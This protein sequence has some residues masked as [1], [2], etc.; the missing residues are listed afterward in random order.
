MVSVPCITDTD[1]SIG[2]GPPLVKYLQNIKFY[3]FLC[4]CFTVK[5]DVNSTSLDSITFAK[6]KSLKSL[7]CVSVPK[8]TKDMNVSFPYVGRVVH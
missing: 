1:T 2:I 5:E 3:K 8:G 6:T 7:F 4:S